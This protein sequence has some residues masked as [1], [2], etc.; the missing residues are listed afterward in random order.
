MFSAGLIDHIGMAGQ[1]RRDLGFDGLDSKSRALCRS[2]SVQE[3]SLAHL[4]AGSRRRC[5]APFAYSFF[6]PRSGD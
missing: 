1:K 3:Y 6:F 5:P 4:G 2:S